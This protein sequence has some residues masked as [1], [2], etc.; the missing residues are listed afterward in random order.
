MCDLYFILLKKFM[1]VWF[2][3]S[4]LAYMWRRQSYD[5]LLQYFEEDILRTFIDTFVLTMKKINCLWLFSKYFQ[6][7]IV[8]LIKVGCLI[9]YILLF[10]CCSKRDL[11][12]RSRQTLHSTSGYYQSCTMIKMN[13]WPS[14]L[15][16]VLLFP[17]LY[18]YKL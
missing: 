5:K 3:T 9:F 6:L 4:F 15:K 13:L 2:K 8:K 12:K 7:V 14:L 18:C 11:K 17:I 16:T 10:N 1:I